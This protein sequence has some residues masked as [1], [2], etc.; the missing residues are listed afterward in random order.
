VDDERGQIAK[1]NRVAEMGQ[2]VVAHENTCSRRISTDS[3]WVTNQASMG[4]LALYHEQF[5]RLGK[6]TERMHEGAETF[7]IQCSQSGPP[8]YLNR[9]GGTPG[10]EMRRLSDLT[11]E[12]RQGKFKKNP[13]PC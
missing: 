2:R 11:H 7:E 5:R 6:L 9:S 13:L 10:E 4:V 8:R 12:T 3:A 1:E